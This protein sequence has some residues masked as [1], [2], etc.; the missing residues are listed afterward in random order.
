MSIEK[1]SKKF[2]ISTTAAEIQKNRAKKLAQKR[3]EEKK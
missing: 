2:G 1:I 3:K